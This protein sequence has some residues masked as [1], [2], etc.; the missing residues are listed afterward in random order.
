M[1][2]DWIIK[3]E[4]RIDKIEDVL[5]HILEYIDSKEQ[6]NNKNQGYQSKEYKKD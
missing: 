3:T 5:N 2:I 6:E 4:K 1:E